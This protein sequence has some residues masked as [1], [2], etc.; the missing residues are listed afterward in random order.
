MTCVYVY[1]GA[2]LCRGSQYVKIVVEFVEYLTN[3]DSFRRLGNFRIHVVQLLIL[4]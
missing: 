3:S 2:H 4:N 1:V